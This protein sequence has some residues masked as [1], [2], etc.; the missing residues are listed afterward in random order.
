ML[1]EGFSG[2]PQPG[3]SR[4]RPHGNLN[5][6]RASILVLFGILALRL[7]QMQILDGADYARRS[8]ENHILRQNILPTRGLV[9][10]RNGTALVQNVG[11]YTATIT[12]E[13]LPENKAD[14]YRIYLR[15]ADLT[16]AQVLDI[17][18]LVQ[19]YE[20]DDL[21]YI[22]IPVQRHLTQEQALML[23]EAAVDM[24]G[25]ALSITP[26]RR[27]TGGDAFAHILGYIGDQSA[28][29]S[30]ALS[31]EGYAFNEPV[32]KDGLESWY[33][34]DLRGDIGYSRVEQDAQGR[35]INALKTIDPVP[36]NSLKLAIDADLQ[37]YVA[38]LLEDSMDDSSGQWGHAR[39]AAAVVMSPT[40]GEVYALVSLPTYDNNI[41]ADLEKRGAEYE[42]LAADRVHEPFLNRALS[43]A[44]PGSTFKLVT[45]AA[46][47]QEGLITPQTS[48]FI[49][50][51][52]QVKGENDEVYPLIDW[53]A[54]GLIDLYQGIA[55]SSNIYMFMASCGILNETRG[56]GKDAETSAV[57]LGQ[58][59][60]AFGFGGATGIDLYGEADGR[61]PSPEW[62]KRYYGGSEFNRGDREW[63][64]ADTCFMGIGQGDVTATP[65]QVARM[66]A[67]VANGGT[68]VTP[69]I[70]NE[71][72]GP[73]GRTV[74][75]IKT[76]TRTVA[77][78]PK[79]LRVVRDG[80]HLS[81]TSGAGARAAQPGIDIAGKTGTAEFFEKGNLKQH[82]WFTGFA[83]FDKP[84]VVV[85]VYFDLG[86]GGDKAAPVAGQI[87]KYFMDN[88]QR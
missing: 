61:V 19:R 28:E 51:V 27:Y 77:V 64:Y 16:G 6:L 81:V 66:T 73:D 54:H 88:V 13:F 38:Q 55:W 42:A 84:E 83:P 32:G 24:P 23:E 22:A 53:R 76:D 78:D 35:L 69:H 12:P 62:K 40:T 41:F 30:K 59:A 2:R 37:S 67:A 87:I 34:K 74:R 56:L 8:R 72:V 75:T 49:P 60:R 79:H 50:K 25:V 21:A 82:A 1:E 57:I 36:G 63:Y 47:L 26:G 18:T 71:V 80:M 52:L 9:L 3:S 14:R 10:D 33:E 7:V 39:V 70:V 11:N 68:L 29:E 17:Q 31:A 44:A 43:E 65:L 5:I 15:L 85:T 86:V 45:A 4:N 20:D 58:Y 46:A 48:R